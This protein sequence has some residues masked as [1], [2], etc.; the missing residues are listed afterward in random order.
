MV[1]LLETLLLLMSPIRNQLFH[2][3]YGSLIHIDI[4]DIF[5]GG[6]GFDI[7]CGVRLMRTN[8]SLE[9]NEKIYGR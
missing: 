6:V 3:V 9:V 5:L 1:S 8:L 2:Q 7:N 4:C